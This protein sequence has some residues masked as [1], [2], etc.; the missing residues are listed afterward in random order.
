MLH[1]VSTDGTKDVILQIGD[2][3]GLHTSGYLGGSGNFTSFDAHTDGFGMHNIGAAGVLTGSITLTL[4]DAA[5]F[6]YM[7]SGIIADTSVGAQVFYIAGSVTLDTVLTLITLTSTATA[8]D[9]DAG[10][11][12]IMLE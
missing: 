12:N 2:S 9:F 10:A 1:G 4:E 5:N 11:M 6:T 8:D 3:G 7:A